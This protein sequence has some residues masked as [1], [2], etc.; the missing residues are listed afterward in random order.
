MVQGGKLIMKYDDLFA[1]AEK[2]YGVPASVIV[3]FLGAR[4]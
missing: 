1:R 3:G 4:K 2:Q